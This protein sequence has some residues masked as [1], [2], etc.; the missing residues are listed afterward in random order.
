V[1]YFLIGVTFNFERHILDLAL[2]LL[3]LHLHLVALGHL[4]LACGS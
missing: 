1:R 3:E 4:Q 2:A